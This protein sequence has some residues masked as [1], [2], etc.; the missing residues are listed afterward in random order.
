M[1][2]SRHAENNARRDDPIEKPFQRPRSRLK[3]TPQRSVCS[4]VAVV[5]LYDT[6]LGLSVL[7][8]KEV[9]RGCPRPDP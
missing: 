1:A 9:G 4:A 2:H 5:P 7:A 3:S 8:A 6:L